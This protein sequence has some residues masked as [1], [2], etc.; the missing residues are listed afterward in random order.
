MASSSSQ[1]VHFPAAS[2]RRNRCEK[3]GRLRLMSGVAAILETC[4]RRLPLSRGANFSV[5]AS[6]ARTSAPLRRAPGMSRPP[7]DACSRRSPRTSHNRCG[8]LGSEHREHSVP[9]CSQRWL[10]CDREVIV[11]SGNSD[12]DGCGGSARHP[13][14][15]SGAHYV[16]WLLAEHGI[17][18]WG[19][20][21][22][23]RQGLVLA[24]CL[25]TNG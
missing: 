7:C 22:G 12:D 9:T 6:S 21:C 1:A 14:P 8:E 24:L 5:V 19:P 13:L 17:V 16:L 18:C 2:A 4:S 10:R 15:H 3:T 11:A 20:P 25:W 23:T